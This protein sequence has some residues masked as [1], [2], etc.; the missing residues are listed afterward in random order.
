MYC[1]GMVMLCLITLEI[2]QKSQTAHQ[3]Q[4]KL[5]KSKSKYPHICKAI[6]LMI[7]ENSKERIDLESLHHYF[8][9]YV[10]DDDMKKPRTKPFYNKAMYG[11][12]QL[13]M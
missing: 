8:T 10:Q 7:K 13:Q 2:P 6:D 3:I 1:L 9:K 5:N 11:R 4:E 12:L